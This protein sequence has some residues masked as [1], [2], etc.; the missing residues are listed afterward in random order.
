MYRFQVHTARAAGLQ[1]DSYSKMGRL[2]G[3]GDYDATGCGDL[4][5]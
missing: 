4:E 1:A 3:C 2:T 5:N